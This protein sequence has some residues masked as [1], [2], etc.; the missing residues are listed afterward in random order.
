MKKITEQQLIESARALKEK[1]T[2]YDAPSAWDKFRN[3]PLSATWQSL[4]FTQGEKHFSDPNHTEG[5]EIDSDTLLDVLSNQFNMAGYAGEGAIK[6]MGRWYTDQSKDEIKDKK[7]IGALERIAQVQNAGGDIN[8][9]K[10]SVNVDAHYQGPTLTDPKKV[11][12]G[13]V[14]KSSQSSAQAAPPVPV[15]PPAPPV[16]VPPPAP[17]QSSAQAGVKPY[18]DAAKEARY[19]A[20]L[21]AQGGK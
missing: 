18:D 21:K 5:S 4:P 17:P 20:W 13:A 15:P 2:E 14:T 12:L 10:K 9:M 11:A 1:L 8:A 6:H 7:M 16:P 19:Q 3:H